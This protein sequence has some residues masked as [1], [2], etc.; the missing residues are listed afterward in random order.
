MTVTRA[1]LTI[2]A[3]DK[4]RPANTANPKFTATF[5]G[6]INGDTPQNTFGIIPFTY[7]RTNSPA[8]DY[9]IGV[10]TF[11]YARGGNY[12]PR[13]VEGTL[14]IAG[15]PPPVVV[16][17]ST[18]T[19]PGGGFTNVQLNGTYQQ[20][21]PLTLEVID[22]PITP[23]TFDPSVLTSGSTVQINPL[24]NTPLE[25]YGSVGIE[26]IQ[27]LLDSI[28]SNPPLTVNGFANQLSNSATRDAAWG[29]LVPFLFSRLDA[30][31][32]KPESQWT[33]AEREF[34][35]ATGSYI[36]QQRRAA[37]AKALA[38]FEAWARK[39][40]D[41]RQA[42]LAKAQ[43]V[44]GVYMSAILASEPPVPPPYFLEQARL[45]M[46]MSDDQAA[47]FLKIDESLTGVQRGVQ[48]L[49]TS[50]EIAALGF[51]FGGQGASTQN[52]A[53]VLGSKFTGKLFPYYSVKA[54]AGPG[55]PVSAVGAVGKGLGIGGA[56]LQVI[57][58][59]VQI[60]VSSSL[61]DQQ[62]KYLSAFGT[63]INDANR[64]S[65]WATSRR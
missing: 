22:T 59:V 16:N 26:V 58:T 29:M 49:Q 42:R 50:A 45:G 33:S 2:R 61:Y 62:A 54:A 60:G 39:T 10:L 40:R 56:V 20:T 27:Q 17:T 41:E 55:V 37:A 38:D 52:I 8:G 11:P 1:P 44:G 31:L 51:Q 43:G 34:V 7:A 18:N 19:G 25:T 4:A 53:S 32:A 3:D 13:T 30:I 47:R 57:G 65:P 23:T 21:T 35:N 36:Q 5:T 28:P 48:G 6:L 46:T 24:L 14:R 63:A 12:E 15:A 9:A 64:P